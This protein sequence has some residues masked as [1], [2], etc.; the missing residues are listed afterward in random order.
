MRKNR[1]ALGLLLAF[2]I[3]FSAACAGAEPASAPASL[4]VGWTLWQ[5]DYTLLIANQMGFFKDH[6]VKVEP[7]RYDSSTQVS[8]DLAG[9]ELDGGL[10][11][12][13]DFLLASNLADIKA[14]MV[15]DNGGQ[16]S[17][18]ASPDIQSL[19]GLRGKRIGVN[20]HTSG[21]LFVVDML[22]TKFMTSNDVT[23]V[24]MT[25]DKVSQ[26]I[27]AQIDAGLVWEPYTTQALKQGKVVV[28]RSDAISSLIPKMIVFRSSVIDQRPQDM[29]A[30]I[31]AWDEAVQYRSS[32]PQ[33]ALAI[34]SQATGLSSNDIRIS[35]NINLY[36]IQYNLILFADTTGTDPNSIYTI[37]G[38]NRDFLITA[39]Y[40]TNPPDLNAL[41][42]PSFLK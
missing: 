15:S 22:K 13:S 3:C 41:I 27:P 38:K 42:D 4:K 35:G 23:F 26:N 7:V 32:H 19:N 39:G 6:G 10:L 17:I 1:P 29:R 16:Y 36:T 14:I 25:P 31:Q 21:E 11:T 9:A 24:D 28:F 18:V 2:I 33:E 8:L 37:A 12:M 5:G 20:L 40:L 30:F 34:I